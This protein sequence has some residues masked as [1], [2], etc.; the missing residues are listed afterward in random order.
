M[1]GGWMR[2]TVPR[3]RSVSRLRREA[4]WMLR[5]IEDELP[6]TRVL[7][8]AEQKE[9]ALEFRLVYRGRLPAETSKPRVAEKHNIRKTFHQQLA[10]LWEQCPELRAQKETRWRVVEDPSDRALTHP[11]KTD[12]KYVE[13]HP[14]GTP[15]IEHIARD[16]VRCG[17]RF[18]PLVRK[19]GGVS[20]S[21]DILFLR[22]DNP[23]S[24]VRSGG[25]IDNR[26]KVL[27]DALRI[28][29]NCSELPAGTVPAEG[30]DPFFCLLEDD[31]L[32]T[33]VSVTTDRLLAPLEGTESI[34]DVQLIIRV[35]LADA[36]GVFQGGRLV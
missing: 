13:H 36:G 33:E 14:S 12:V 7:R 8:F 27:F 26:V 3:S 31:A 29:D 2:S 24:I 30:E 25:D 28:V 9:H 5:R 20:C 4:F 34:N 1:L 15:W 6:Q 21:I 10:E 32:I 19:Y 35:K 16:Y 17:F 18:V 11:V 23:G 22:R